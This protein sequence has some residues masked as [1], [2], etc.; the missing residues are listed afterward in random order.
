MRGAISHE[1]IYRLLQDPRKEE[2]ERGRQRM[3]DKFIDIKY[4]DV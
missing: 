3:Y 2:R 1:L 4:L